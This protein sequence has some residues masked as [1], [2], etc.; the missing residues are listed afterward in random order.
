MTQAR[1][2]HDGHEYRD[3]PGV[4]G[5]PGP[6]AGGT[7]SWQFPG[8]GRARA[9]PLSTVAAARLGFNSVSE[10]RV[11]SVT[12]HGP[13]AAAAGGKPEG[14][15]AASASESPPRRRPPAKAATAVARGDS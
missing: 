1:R 11:E 6:P 12:S 9:L 8:P 2:H 5:R 15:A 3:L 14:T 10:S 4:R 13:V 7:L